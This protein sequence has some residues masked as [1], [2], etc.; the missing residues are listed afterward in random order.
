MLVAMTID[1]ARVVLGQSSFKVSDLDLQRDI[2]VAQFFADV[3]FDFN[4]KRKVFPLGVPMELEIRVK[5]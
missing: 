4:L 3:F 5:M 2:D 1:E